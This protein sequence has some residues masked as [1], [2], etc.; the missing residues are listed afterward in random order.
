ML[1]G[2]Y[3]VNELPHLS[4]LITY[5]CLRFYKI[6]LDYNRF[7]RTVFNPYVQ[8]VMSMDTTGNLAQ[9]EWRAV[10]D[11]TVWKIAYNLI[12]AV[13]AIIAFL[14]WIGAAFMIL[15]LRS[16]NFHE[17]KCLALLGLTLGIMLWFL[18]FMGISGEWFLAWQSR[19]WSG[20]QPGFR[21]AALFFLTLLYLSQQER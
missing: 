13:E 6:V 19:S 1:L 20:I 7:L 5:P 8:H 18:A 12:I 11:P 10:H 15:N 14:C 3:Q 2:L 9:A 4:S 17:S 21:V 16:E